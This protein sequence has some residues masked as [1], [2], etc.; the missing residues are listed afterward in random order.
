MQ[1]RGHLIDVPWLIAG[2]V[3]QALEVSDKMGGRHINQMQAGKLRAMIDDCQLIDLGYQ[4]PKF[5]WTN[6]QGVSAT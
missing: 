6:G 2:D 1:H 5:T 3:N 4:G